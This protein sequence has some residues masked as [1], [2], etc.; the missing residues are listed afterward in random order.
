MSRRGWSRDELVVAFNLYCK[1]RFGQCHGRNPHVVA[2]AKALGRTPGA[3]AMKLCN[4]A[5]LDPTHQRR[6]IAGLGNASQADRQVWD[7][8]NTD[9]DRLAP[10]SEAAFRAL[11]GDRAAEMAG[12][13]GPSSEPEVVAPSA[14]RT[15]TQ[16]PQKVRLGQAFFRAAVLAS[17]NDRCCI[18]LLLCRALLVAS[19][20]VPWAVRPELRLD[21]RNGLCLCALHDKAFDRRL[22]SVDPE[23]RV[24]LS[25]SIEDQMPHPV[26]EHLFIAFR[27]QPIH[28]P[29][30]FRPGPEHLEYHRTKLF[31]AG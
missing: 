5:S 10:E 25:R 27:G 28:L 14:E 19:H 20:I 7:E 13:G 31:Q 18:C 22:I 30:K 8:F 16:R 11:L 17:Y 23:F 29:D 6:G 3:V 4:F 24:L 9:W 15:E 2:L 12:E 1:L 21:P 26:I